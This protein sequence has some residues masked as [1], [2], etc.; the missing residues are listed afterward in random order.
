[1]ATPH[2]LHTTAIYITHHT[3][4][5]TPLHDLTKNDLLSKCQPVFLQTPCIALPGQQG[6]RTC[7]SK[8]QG[9]QGG[10]P[11]AHEDSPAGARVAAAVVLSSACNAKSEKHICCRVCRQQ[12]VR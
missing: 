6:F 1:M 12:I 10:R 9:R 3:P 2:C 4:N 8:A 5:H 11:G 7:H